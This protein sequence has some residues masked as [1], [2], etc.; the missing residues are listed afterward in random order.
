MWFK[1]FIC[2]GKQIC[3]GQWE[4]ACSSAAVSEGRLFTGGD[5]AGQHPP[6]SE[7]P[8]R[9]QRRHP[10][11]DA[12]HSWFRWGTNGAVSVALQKGF[13]S[14]DLLHGAGCCRPWMRIKLLSYLVISVPPRASQYP[15]EQLLCP[16]LL[17]AWNWEICLPCSRGLSLVK[18]GDRCVRMKS[19][20]SAL[21]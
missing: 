1:F 5:G 20:T 15:P 4:S 16:I 18:L 19:I 13:Q 9:L 17:G 7:L 3:D 6:A 8:E 12:S 11:A 2:K 14:W 21:W 10:V